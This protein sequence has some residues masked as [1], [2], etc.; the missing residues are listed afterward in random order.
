MIVDGLISLLTHTHACWLPSLLQTER[1][2]SFSRLYSRGGSSI[3]GRPL[4]LL[5]PLPFSTGPHLQCALR[6]RE[7][8]KEE[9]R[10]MQ[11][12]AGQEAPEKERKQTDVASTPSL[13]LPSPSPFPSPSFSLTGKASSV[14]PPALQQVPAWSSWQL[15]L[16]LPLQQRCCLPS[17]PC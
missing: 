10:T 15:T 6:R 4:L 8:K 14:W 11:P 12:T 13:S 3:S 16:P 17:C 1:V 2:S 7:G 9:Q 5:S